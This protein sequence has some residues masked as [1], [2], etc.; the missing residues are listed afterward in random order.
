MAA[1]GDNLAFLAATADGL[2]DAAYSSGAAFDHLL[3]VE[4]RLG[5]RGG[6]VS[7]VAV[8]L[9]AAAVSALLS[10]RDG[11]RRIV[12]HSPGSSDVLLQL[13]ESDGTARCALAWDGSNSAA[14][15][16]GLRRLYTHG[17]VLDDRN[18]TSA[19][20]AGSPQDSI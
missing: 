12:D 19:L 9:V 3:E 2:A 20:S 18:E 8:D 6:E 1:A 13:N 17:V 15:R 11:S 7:Q 16:R 14:S 5:L 4:Q 10:P